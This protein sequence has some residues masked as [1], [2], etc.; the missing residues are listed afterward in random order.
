MSLLLIWL[1]MNIALKTVSP[2]PK[3]IN[4]ILGWY[5]VQATEKVIIHTGIQIINPPTVMI[6]AKD[7]LRKPPT[8]GTN[9]KI[10]MR[11]ANR[12]QNPTTIIRKDI[13]LTKNVNF[14]VYLFLL[15]KISSFVR[16]SSNK[17]LISVMGTRNYPTH[18]QKMQPKGSSSSLIFLPLFWY[19]AIGKG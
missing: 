13:P 6:K 12:R 3:K 7:P 17:K 11:G 10:S 5:Q 1:Y 8:K 15:V 2:V 19:S 18:A 14:L 9:P 4:P 16:V